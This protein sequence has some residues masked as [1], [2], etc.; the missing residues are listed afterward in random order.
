MREKVITVL[1][2]GYLVVSAVSLTDAAIYFVSEGHGFGA[3]LFCIMA[4]L[5]GAL[6]AKVFFAGLLSL[7]GKQGK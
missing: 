2:L 6:I 5:W 4:F 3:V 7:L 1:Y